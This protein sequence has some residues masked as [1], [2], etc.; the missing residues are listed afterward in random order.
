[1]FRE[2]VYPIRPSTTP[3]P[4]TSTS[5]PGSSPCCVL[6]T[7]YAGSCP[8][9][10]YWRHDRSNLP[11][12]A[13]LARLQSS[14]RWR[15]HSRHRGR[16][17]DPLP[18]CGADRRTDA[19]VCAPSPPLAGPDPARQAGAEAPGRR[20]SLRPTRPCP[21]LRALRRPSPSPSSTTP[22]ASVAREIANP[23]DPFLACFYK[24][25]TQHAALTV[26]VG[27]AR[28]RGSRRSYPR[29]PVP[30]QCR[31]APRNLADSCHG[32]TRASSCFNVSGIHFWISSFLL[33][34]MECEGGH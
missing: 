4:R 31:K 28:L 30:E 32:T 5:T 19:R 17:P 6:R 11:A 1:M 24:P 12:A 15:S 14:F 9:P 22:L 13:F 3:I 21:C 2:P 8:L 33:L 18:S 34:S 20:T 27:L 29:D 10:S 7:S 26:P 23:S 16:E 25:D